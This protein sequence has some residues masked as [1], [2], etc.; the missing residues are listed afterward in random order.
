MTVMDVGPAAALNGT[1]PHVTSPTVN[2]TLDTLLAMR[3]D[4]TLQLPFPPVVHDAVPVSPP[5][6][7]PE[8]VALATGLLEASTIMM[9]TVA[10]QPDFPL[11]DVAE[12]SEATRV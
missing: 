10:R 11:A 8:T 9:V 5:A 4:V 3:R 2:V 6:Q 7:F 12:L 1:V